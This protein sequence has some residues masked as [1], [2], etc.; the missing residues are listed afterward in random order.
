MPDPVNPKAFLNL[1]EM[2]I[3]NMYELEAIGELLEQKRADDQGSDNYA[4]ERTETQ[5]S[6]NRIP[7]RFHIRLNAPP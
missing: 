7:H 5:N 3:D 2:A 6:P 4:R 1:C